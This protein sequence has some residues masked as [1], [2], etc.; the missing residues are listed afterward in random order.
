MQLAS[1]IYI[2]FTLWESSRNEILAAP[3]TH[4]IE[5]QAKTTFIIELASVI[6]DITRF[7]HLVPVG[8]E[9]QGTS[10]KTTVW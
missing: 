2:Y 5:D 10:N 1:T 4:Y 6:S 7:D 9:R 3:Y 8:L